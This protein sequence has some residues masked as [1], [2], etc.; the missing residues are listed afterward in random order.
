[1]SSFCIEKKMMS[2]VA[3]VASTFAMDAAA[4]GGL[5]ILVAAQREMW[6]KRSGIK[7]SIFWT[8]NSLSVFI[9]FFGFAWLI[10][11]SE[12]KC[13]RTGRIRHVLL[14]FPRTRSNVFCYGYGASG[15]YTKCNIRG[16]F[17]FHKISKFSITFITS[18][19]ISKY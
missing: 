7:A 13:L 6:W 17:S 4:S 10:K 9:T 14:D 16:V 3:G 2:N 11:S 8:R 18:S 19:I 15:S 1:M 12:A 5:L